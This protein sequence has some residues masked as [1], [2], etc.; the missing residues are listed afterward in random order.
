MS[1]LVRDES[2]QWKSLL[3][4]TVSGLA[5][6]IHFDSLP[7]V[8]QLYKMIAAVNGKHLHVKDVG[9]LVRGVKGVAP[10]GM[11]EAAQ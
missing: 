2:S 7:E 8:Q 11:V 10:A 3:S 9:D 4:M 1:M 5:S 6:M